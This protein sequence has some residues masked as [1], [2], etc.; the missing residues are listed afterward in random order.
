M[1]I[2]PAD[3]LLP[4]LFKFDAENGLG[5]N[6]QLLDLGFES[7]NCVQ[8]MGS[9]FFYIIFNIGL[10]IVFKLLAIVSKYSPK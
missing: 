5:I 2:L 6:Q 1:D 9:T 10:M 3:L 4:L 8:N 7:T